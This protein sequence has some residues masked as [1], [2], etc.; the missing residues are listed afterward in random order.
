VALIEIEFP[1]RPTVEIP[2]DVRR[3]LDEADQRIEEHLRRCP[4]KAHGF[5]ASD[6][7][8][9]YDALRKIAGSHLST[10]HAFCEWG[11]GFGVATLLA[12][13][14][15][16]DACGI[17]VDLTLVS[18]A[19]ELAADFSI[20]ADFVHGSFIPPDDEELVDRDYA[21]GSA[22]FCWLVTDSDDAYEQLGLDADD[23]DLVYAYPW[24]N[25]EHVVEN[26]FERH[27]ADGALLLTYGH[28][29]SMRLL[30]KQSTN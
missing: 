16:F 12:A 13:M 7:V 28:L 8:A 4:A 19:Q 9:A 22:E 18:A 15:D 25:E 3:L 24:P 11:S 26:L 1:Q 29:A 10:G 21:A 30:R 5:V 6:F 27:A 20:D 17:E 2:P 14:L 23:F